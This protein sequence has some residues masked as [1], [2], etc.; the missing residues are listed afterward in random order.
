MTDDFDLNDIM[1][2]ATAEVQ[3]II[4][5]LMVELSLPQQN[6]AL[7]Q[8]RMSAP[9]EMKD[10]SA[11]S[12]QA[13]LSASSRQADQFAS[14]QPDLSAGAM[15]APQRGRRVPAQADG[16]RALMKTITGG[17]HA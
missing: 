10:L 5:E 14:E 11:S 9:D 12:R 17:K 2:E 7:P 16:Y 3:E 6:R 4:R 13:D 1:L 8:S 15:P